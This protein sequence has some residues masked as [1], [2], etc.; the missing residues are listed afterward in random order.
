MNLVVGAT[1]YL[2]SEI[3]ELLAR[4]GKQVRAL[5]R[6]TSDPAK[7][8][9]LRD[10]GVEIVEGD[11]REPSTLKNAWQGINAVISTASAMP[12][13]YQPEANTPDTTDRDGLGGLIEAAKAAGVSRFVYTSFSRNIDLDFSLRN[14]KRET[15]RHLKKSGLEY[16]ILRP[17]YF[18]EA[19]LSP[20]V[21]FD[22][23]NGKATI[24][25]SGRNPVSW[26]S[27][28]DVARLAV[29]TLDSPAAANATIELGG[30]EPINPL[31]V[32]RVFEKVGGRQLEVQHVP[33]EALRAQ[34]EAATD[35]MQKSFVGLMRCLAAGDSIDMRGTL[36][37][38]PVQLTSVRDYAAK[39]LG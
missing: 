1:G 13:S 5:V 17:S 34:S 39:V 23:A 21:G 10:L 30:P 7:V 6:P 36:K 25:G 27:R 24:Y 2:G 37:D 32:V 26:I 18:M 3:C 28:P 33:E 31:E 38:F 16:T 29:A 19:W 8:A 22:P 35:P 4:Q 15:E 9:K 12:F 20:A 14:A 11:L